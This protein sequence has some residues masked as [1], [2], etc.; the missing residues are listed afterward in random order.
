MATYHTQFNPVDGCR[1]V[2]YDLH[3]K[4]T[5]HQTIQENLH[6]EVGSNQ[7]HLGV[8]I[9]VRGDLEGTARN[10]PAAQT[11]QAQVHI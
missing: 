5:S 7:F 11:P 9:H 10:P 1:R 2:Q 3:L 4:Y 6:A 8:L